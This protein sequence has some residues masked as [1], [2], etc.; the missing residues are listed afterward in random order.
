MIRPPIDPQARNAVE[1]QLEQDDGSP[2]FWPRMTP[3]LLQL[4]AELQAAVLYQYAVRLRDAGKP[5]VDL[6]RLIAVTYGESFRPL[7]AD[8][9]VELRT[10]VRRPPLLPCPYR[11]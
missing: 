9:A 11:K 5:Y 1:A 8:P 2:R 3:S 7:V 6:A 10:D 4:R